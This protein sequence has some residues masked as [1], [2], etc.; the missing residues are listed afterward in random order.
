MSN[1]AIPVILGTQDFFGDLVE[2]ERVEILRGPQG[3][4]FGKNSLGGAIEYVTKE[5]SD[6]LDANFVATVASYH[7]A[8]PQGRGESGG[9]LCYVDR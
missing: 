8:D 1:R 5:P 7:R 2:L 9:E 4:L 3:T 6:P